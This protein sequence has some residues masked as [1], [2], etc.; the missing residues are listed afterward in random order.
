MSVTIL[1]KVW[2]VCSMGF[3]LA[4]AASW[5]CAGEEAYEARVFRDGEETLPYRLLVPAGYDPVESYPLVLFLHGAGERGEDNSAQLKH[6][7]SIFTTPENREQYPAFVVVPQCPAGV[8]WSEV[9]LSWEAQ[10]FSPEP[11]RPLALVRK[12]LDALEE[13]YSIDADRR[14]VMGLSMGGFGT[15][16]ALARWPDHFAAGVPICGGADLATAE[17]IAGIPVWVFHGARDPVV[18]VRLSRTMVEA[19][20]AAGGEP[21]Y[22][23]YPEA[24]HD[25]WTPASQEPELLP[26]LFAQRRGE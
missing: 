19:L 4:L 21:R 5:A 9:D 8:W 6:V 18:P 16:D 10:R 15:W 25:S 23:E 7:V 26:W 22:T 12:L 3:V 11:S 2:L 24:G 17:K 13:E 14:Y 20:R 1:S